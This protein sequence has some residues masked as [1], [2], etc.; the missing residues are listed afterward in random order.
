MLVKRVFLLQ[1]AFAV[2]I[3]DLIFRLHLAPF[4]IILTN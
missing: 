4:V 1:A 2:V 3:L